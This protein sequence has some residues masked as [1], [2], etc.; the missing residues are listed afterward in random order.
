MILEIL[1]EIFD[2]SEV[3]ATL[4]PLMVFFIYK[5]KAD[6]IKPLFVFLLVT[7]VFA[8]LIDFTWK[9]RGMGL[10]KF[11]EQVFGWLYLESNGKKRLFNVIF[12]NANSFFRLILITWFF[13]RL[14]PHYK[15]VFI[16]ITLLFIAGGITNFIVFENIM[17]NFSSRLFTFEAG[18]ILF[19]CLLY[20]YTVT[21][22]DEI[23]SP[24]AL[25]SFWAVMGFTFYNAVN[26]LIFLFFNYLIN[27]EQQFAKQIWNVHNGIYI[28]LM[29][30]IAVAFNKARKR[31]FIL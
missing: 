3:W 2:W 12:Y 16:V 23:I 27:A 5:P 7:L 18:I 15:K 29:I 6:W 1:K 26:F 8:L 20:Y 17:R 24:I 10:Q 14:I 13:Y 31:T 11:S 19:Y 22:N 28:V 21:M 9:S 4:I 30:F 25:P